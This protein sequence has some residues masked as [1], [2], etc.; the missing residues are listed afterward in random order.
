MI[1]I[2]ELFQRSKYFRQLIVGQFKELLSLAVGTHKALPPPAE[3][4]TLLREK[5]LSIIEHWE[6]HHGK[7][8]KQLVLGYNY[9]RYTLKM[10]FPDLEN[11]ATRQEQQR[12]EQE[13]RLQKILKLKFD[14]IPQEMEDMVGDMQTN[15]KQMVSIKSH[16][17]YEYKT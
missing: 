14:R 7:H 4:A 2:D 17:L 3:T 1:I 12:Q 11:A 6:K 16:Q 8:Y 10:Q 13:L 15:I 9:L 5:S